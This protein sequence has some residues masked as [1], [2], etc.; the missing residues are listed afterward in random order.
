[1]LDPC[2]EVRI[3]E[4]IDNWQQGHRREMGREP[5]RWLHGSHGGEQV[6]AGASTMLLNPN[7]TYPRLTMLGQAFFVLGSLSTHHSFL[8][9]PGTLLHGRIS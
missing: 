3:S 7:D 9:G 5:Q 8:C 1:M 6:G 4:A 2:R